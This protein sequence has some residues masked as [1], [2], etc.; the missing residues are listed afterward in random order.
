MPH[1][2]I[3]VADCLNPLGPC[4]NVRKIIEPTSAR[5]SQI[6]DP[7]IVLHPA[8]ANTPAYYIMYMTG[9][10]DTTLSTNG[11]YYATSWATDGITW[12]KPQLLMFGYWLPSATWK[13]D[14]VE[15]YANSTDTGVADVFNLG[16]SGV[17]IGTPAML[18][19]DNLIS[20]PPYYSNI[21]VEWR[22]NISM[23]QMLAERYLSTTTNTSSVID[24][25]SSTDGIHW[26]LQYPAII[27]PKNGQ[28]R[29]GTPAQN[30]DSAFFVYFGS[31]AEQ[32]SEGFE[33]NAARWNAPVLGS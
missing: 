15:L 5:L 31:T 11:I 24:Y 28:F 19:F 22:S 30:P 32:H 17:T 6:N 13:N 27:R 29:V 18:V 9:A 14:H 23:Y 7:S 8:S 21:N 33:I 4:T 3:F 16:A 2:S 20:V 25:L 26:H 10:I 1:D 12:S